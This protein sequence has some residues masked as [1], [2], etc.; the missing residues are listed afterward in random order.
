MS[1]SGEEKQ[2]SC[3]QILHF[4]LLNMVVILDKKDQSD[5]DTIQTVMTK[6]LAQS[7]SKMAQLKGCSH[8]P[9]M[10]LA[11][12]EYLIVMCYRQEESFE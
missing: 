10:R 7:I 6:R 2:I 3:P 5:F 11:S 1:G 4:R 12:L 8:S 9:V